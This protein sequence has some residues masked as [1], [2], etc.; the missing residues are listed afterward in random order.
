MTEYYFLASL[1]PALE[2]GHV[3][4]LGFAE[5]KQL[6]A[7]NLTNVDLQKTQEFLRYV[8]LENMRRLFSNE[9]QDPRGNLNAEELRE[10]IA[11]QQ[12]PNGDPFPEYMVEYFDKYRTE[13]ERL[14]HF[15]ELMSAYLQEESEKESGF[16]SEYFAFERGLRIVL[17]GFRAKKMNKNVE[18]VLQYEDAADPVVAQV[19][20]QKD[21]KS[22]E[23]PF[24]Y[25][26]LKT[27]FDALGEDPLELN[28]AITAYRFSAIVEMMDAKHFSID[29]ILG[30]MARLILVER[31][32]ELDVEKGI[33]IIDTIERSV[34]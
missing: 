16:I 13:P 7:I 3:P 2:I 27:I 30:Y 23:P 25:K 24:E 1:L 20:A 21:A 6:L 33:E 22:Y 18:A 31:W 26:E 5:L 19:I 14:E 17:A 10:A 9:P 8:D 32:L 28:K 4:T 29:R 12:F 11:E 15:S 34:T